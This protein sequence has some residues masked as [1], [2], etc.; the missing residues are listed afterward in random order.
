M[1]L[2]NMP[3]IIRS[4]VLI[5]M[6]FKSI[7]A[8][9]HLGQCRANKAFQYVKRMLLLFRAVV[10]FCSA[11]RLFKFFEMSLVESQNC[12]CMPLLNVASCKLTL[13]MGIPWN[14][15]DLTLVNHL[16]QICNYVR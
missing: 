11:N 5:K 14:W 6:K 13:S 10:K 16:L 15:T 9:F 1:H 2:Q 7:S 12:Y 8:D 4:F 3:L